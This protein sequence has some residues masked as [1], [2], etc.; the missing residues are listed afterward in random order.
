MKEISNKAEL[1]SKEA[2]KRSEALDKSM[3]EI[4]NKAELRSKEADKRSDEA[5]KR[6]KELS[7]SIKKCSLH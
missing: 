6:Q 1:R 4:S 3:K 5:D 7:L 2:D